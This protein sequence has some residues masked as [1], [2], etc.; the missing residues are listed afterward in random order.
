MY[1]SDFLSVKALR[2]TRQEKIADNV[3]SS[4]ASAFA[5]VSFAGPESNFTNVDT[6]GGKENYTLDGIQ[7][8]TGASILN[9]ASFSGSAG[10]QNVT[11]FQSDNTNIM[12]SAMMK[13]TTVSTIDLNYRKDLI[14]ISYP[15][16]SG[17]KIVHDPSFSTVYQPHQASPS[18]ISSPAD[19]DANTGD[20]L[21]LQWQVSD[22]DSNGDTYKI[23][24]ETNAVIDSGTW[25]SGSTI[26]TSI[27]VKDGV[28]KYTLT[29]TDKDGNTD[30]KTVTITGKT[31]NTN[32][33]LST[34]SIT[35]D[36]PSNITTA[37]PGFTLEVLLILSVVSLISVFIRKFKK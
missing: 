14:L 15:E 31:L 16:W 22:P 26:K 35:S 11:T 18:I 25:N 3:T 21:I 5:S 34:A 9:L 20:T 6:R 29:I 28:H 27:T 32:T 7:H 1:Q 24:D 2:A 17:G 10:A 19:T 23:T 12:N 30:S 8:T 13:N 33:G 36:R 37:A 4:R